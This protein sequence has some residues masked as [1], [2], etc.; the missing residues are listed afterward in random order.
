MGL[1]H[2]GY[3]TEK[4]LAGEAFKSLGKNVQIYK[5]C[6]VVGAKNISVGNNVRI[7]AFCSIVVPE[8]GFLEIGS[9]VH[10]G[11]FCHLSASNGIII[12]DFSGISQRVTIYSRT[13]DFSGKYM[14]GPTVPPEYTGG[15][16][17]TV[18][19]K[20]H[21]IVGSSSVVLPGVTIGEGTSVGALSLV[22]KD[23]EAW[24]IYVGVPAKRIKARSKDLLLLE[25]KLLDI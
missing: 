7:D 18:H 8:D 22:N 24:S 4:E 9:Y 11:A 13:D 16:S 5:N 20:R 17:G 15:Y 12:N 10:I 6:T 2:I 14:T 3:Y 23:L 19:L 1:M 25:Q 21:V